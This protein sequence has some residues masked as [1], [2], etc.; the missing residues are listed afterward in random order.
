MTVVT[1]Q[2]DYYNLSMDMLNIWTLNDKH[3]NMNKYL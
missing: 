3:V 1:L 2:D